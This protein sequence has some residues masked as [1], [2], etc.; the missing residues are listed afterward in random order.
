MKS[1]A[2]VF[3]VLPVFALGQIL[4]EK[5]A[6]QKEF[7]EAFQASVNGLEAYKKTD[8][9]LTSCNVS[10]FFYE[11]D[12]GIWGLKMTF[13]CYAKDEAIRTKDMLAEQVEGALPS[14]DF[15][16]AKSYGASY[17]DY[18]KWAFEFD[19]PTFAEKKKRPSI[20]IGALQEGDDYRVVVTLM[21]PYFKNQYSPNW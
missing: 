14:A 9:V 12:K 17:F 18:L 19:S 13:N 6:F 15:K 5:E 20:E 2:L 7:K 10:E 21:E 1:F 8:P 16:K 4:I 11:E 3:A